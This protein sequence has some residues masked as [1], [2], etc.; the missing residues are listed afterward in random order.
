[1]RVRKGWTVERRRRRSEEK[2]AERRKRQ[3]G[4][5][6]LEAKGGKGRTAERR[7]R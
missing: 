6:W 3:K 7:K 5:G 4:K 1:M 2:D